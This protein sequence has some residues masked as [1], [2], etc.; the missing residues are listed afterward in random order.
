MI[1]LDQSVGVPSGPAP[2]HTHGILDMSLDRLQDVLDETAGLHR[3]SPGARKAAQDLGK[4]LEAFLDD[5]VKLDGYIRQLLVIIRH[6]RG[7]ANPSV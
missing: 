1:D 5:P 2:E 3:L 4:A 6:Y 7:I